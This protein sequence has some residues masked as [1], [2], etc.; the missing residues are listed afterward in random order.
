MEEEFNFYVPVHFFSFVASACN[1]TSWLPLGMLW[2]NPQTPA[3][4]TRDVNYDL[5][6]EWLLI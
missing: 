1:Y 3:K 2:L 4:A 5:A 6:W